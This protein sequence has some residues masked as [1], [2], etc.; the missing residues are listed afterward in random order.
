MCVGFYSPETTSSQAALPSPSPLNMLDSERSEIERKK[1]SRA[2]QCSA[3]IRYNFKMTA[4]ES[5]SASEED[6]WDLDADTRLSVGWSSASHLWLHSD[7]TCEK[8][9]VIHMLICLNSA[10]VK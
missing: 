4:E 9:T 2:V 1:E 6:D 10:A 8:I 5:S 3:A 7:P